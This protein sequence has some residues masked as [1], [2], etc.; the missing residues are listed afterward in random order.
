M[1]NHHNGVERVSLE[2]EKLET[3]NAVVSLGEMQQFQQSDRP[4]SNSTSQ[5]V[6]PME[7][8]D[9]AKQP[10]CEDGFCPG[11]TRHVDVFS[12]ANFAQGEF[13][14]LDKDNNNYITDGE[15]KAYQERFKETMTPKMKAHLDS[16]LS[17]YKANM[18]LSNDEV[19][20]ERSGIT[21]HDLDVMQDIEDGVGASE[22]I[23]AFVDKHFDDADTNKDGKL[24]PDELRAWQSTHKFGNEN[25][26]RHS[27]AMNV[28]GHLSE[29]RNFARAV[30]DYL[31]MT[32]Y[33]SQDQG[34]TKAQAKVASELIKKG[35]KGYTEDFF[36]S[37]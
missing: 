17:N 5:H 16:L 4:Q 29:G 22:R 24:I 7:L 6:K 26:V 23:K 37:K 30:G 34:L 27:D 33:R 13:K 25:P 19:F 8:V 11:G 15:I 10:V 18:T 3:P 28:L 21:M 9:L 31:G 20:F 12:T 1:V 35:I 2:G 14:L 32:D 36:Y